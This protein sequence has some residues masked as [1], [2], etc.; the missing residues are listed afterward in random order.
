MAQGWTGERWTLLRVR[1]LI[2]D[3]LGASLSVQGVRELLRRHGWS[4]RRLAWRAV[5][6]EEAAVAGSRWNRTTRWSNGSRLSVDTYD[7]TRSDRRR[8]RTAGRG[9]RLRSTGIREAVTGSS[10]APQT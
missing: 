10:R 7:R 4:G 5:E 8:L 1:V 9:P 6:R 3:H 2:A